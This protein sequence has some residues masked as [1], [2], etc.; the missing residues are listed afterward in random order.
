MDLDLFSKVRKLFYRLRL[1]GVYQRLSSLLLSTP[2]YITW[3]SYWV[4]DR[5]TNDKCPA[6]SQSG[7]RATRC[8][9]T[10]DA[11]ITASGMGHCTVRAEK[12]LGLA[13]GDWPLG[14][15]NPGQVKIPLRPSITRPRSNLLVWFMNRQD[16]EEYAVCMEYE[17][18]LGQ[19]V[20]GSS[21][22]L[23]GS[24]HIPRPEMVGIVLDGWCQSVISL[25][26]TLHHEANHI[27]IIES[28]IQLSLS[29]LRKSI[30]PWP[31]RDLVKC[32][33]ISLETELALLLNAVISTGAG[34][35]A[36]L[37]QPLR[38]IIRHEMQINFVP[39]FQ[40]WLDLDGLN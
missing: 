15:P 6:V 35:E 2:Y 36:V 18:S 22:T 27:P 5:M 24:M 7:W 16:T 32:P 10:T 19:Y 3:Y 23:Y 26:E 40:S 8:R 38:K 12:W 25:A 9:S 20:V 1:L 34:L 17:Y 30:E 37:V 39:D 14:R 13:R 31:C 29:A 33:G 11:P 21:G 28:N 4:T